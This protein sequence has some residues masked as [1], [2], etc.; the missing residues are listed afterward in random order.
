MLDVTR[1]ID[2]RPYG[3][4]PGE[5]LL[6]CVS[7]KTTDPLMSG[8]KRS[9]RCFPCAARVGLENPSRQGDLFE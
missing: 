2:L 1:L 4:A 8:D 7:C 5:Y 9:W 3:Y 6:R